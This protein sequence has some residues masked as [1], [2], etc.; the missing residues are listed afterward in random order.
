MPAIPVHPS[1]L[2]TKMPSVSP[3]IADNPPGL[4]EILM[5]EDSAT[6]AELALRAFKLAGFA[7]PVTVVPSGE[8]G[9]DYLFG[10]G[11]FAARGPTRP[12]LILL[13]LGL[14][15]MSGIDFLRRIRADGRTRGIPIV[16]LSLSKHNFDVT[17]C[18]QQ[19]AEAYIV[20]PVNFDDFF[21]VTA[22]LKLRLKLVARPGAGG[23]VLSSASAV[24][25]L[26]SPGGGATSAATP[27]SP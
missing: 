25:H 14:P 17:A 8:Q 9:L 4:Q 24:P 3:A 11:S 10:T 2:S 6:D 16:V 1:R 27:T 12:H 15:N 26:N 22:G 7:N 13:D 5:V 21:R 18:I 20:K 23:W 19:G